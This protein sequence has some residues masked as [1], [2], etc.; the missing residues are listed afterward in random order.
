[1]SES[2]PELLRYPH[3]LSHLLEKHCANF[4]VNVAKQVLAIPEISV[5]TTL[6]LAEHEPAFIREVYLMDGETPLVFARSVI[7]EH[8]AYLLTDVLS[9]KDVPLA[10]CLFSD[11]RW[12]RSEFLFSRVS[13]EICLIPPGAQQKTDPLFAR[14]SVFTYC[15]HKILLLEVFLPAIFDNRDIALL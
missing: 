11:N 10:K 8:S 1:M 14:E 12:Q 6:Q 3:S 4:R 13:A 15:P 9:Q 2:Y 5:S 7:P